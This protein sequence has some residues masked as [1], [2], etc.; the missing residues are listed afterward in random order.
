MAMTGVGLSVVRRFASLQLTEQWLVTSEARDHLSVL[1]TP[2]GAAASTGPAIDLNL[3]ESHRGLLMATAAAACSTLGRRASLAGVPPM[4]S[5]GARR[6]SAHFDQL[7][8]HHHVPIG[9]SP[10]TYRV[11]CADPPGALVFNDGAPKMVPV[12][13]F[14]GPGDGLVECGAHVKVEPTDEEERWATTR[15]VVSPGDAGAPRVGKKRKLDNTGGPPDVLN[16]PQSWADKSESIFSRKAI[17]TITEGTRVYYDRVCAEHALEKQRAQGTSAGVPC[18]TAS[19]AG[20]R[21]LVAGPRHVS[22]KPSSAPACVH[23]EEDVVPIRIAAPA[24]VKFAAPQRMLEVSCPSVDYHI[25]PR[26]RVCPRPRPS[27]SWVLEV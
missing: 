1:S 18:V 8:S 27:Q 12:L 25:P 23:V 14:C 22:R 6:V 3:E 7:P 17:R 20:K 19:G 4:A 13:P 16:P 5:L 2:G 21:S 11:S 9:R 26:R 24:A 15:P 10:S